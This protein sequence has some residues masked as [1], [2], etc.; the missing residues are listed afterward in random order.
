ML[1]VSVINQS[2]PPEMNSQWEIYAY[3]N[4]DLN[5][6]IFESISLPRPA[7]WGL[8]DTSPSSHR[9]PF[10]ILSVASLLP[11][12]R[13]KTSRVWFK[14]FKLEN[15]PNQPSFDSLPSFRLNALDT[16]T[17]KMRHFWKNANWTKIKFIFLQKYQFMSDR[18]RRNKIKNSESYSWGDD[19]LFYLWTIYFPRAYS[20]FRMLDF[21]NTWQIKVRSRW[22]ITAHRVALIVCNVFRLI[23]DPFRSTGDGTFVSVTGSLIMRFK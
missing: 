6:H 12:S 21:W 3:A 20:I 19:S 8:R 22:D 14:L 9:G 17:S 5:V 15:S 2:E 13:L 10:N 1:S 16:K 7:A 18:Q 11:I 23:C 4:S